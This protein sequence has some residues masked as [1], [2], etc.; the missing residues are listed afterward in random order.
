M[1]SSSPSHHPTLPPRCAHKLRAKHLLRLPLLLQLSVHGAVGC[2]L[3]LQLSIPAAGVA[4]FG[5]L[6]ALDAKGSGDTADGSQL[7][8]HNNVSPNF[9]THP[10]HNSSYTSY[11]L[12]LVLNIGPHFGSKNSLRVSGF[13]SIN[14]IIWGKKLVHLY[15]KVMA[16]RGGRVG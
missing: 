14:S 16:Q 12:V 4:D 11:S 13:V 10:T 8:C 15:D 6:D 9:P 2:R 3:I 1:G 7:N 5:F